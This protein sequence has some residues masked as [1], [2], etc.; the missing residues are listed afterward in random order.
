MKWVTRILVNSLV[1]LM[2]LFL[3]NVLGSYVGM[4]VGLNLA[5]AAIA[6]ILGVPGFALI[7]ILQYLGRV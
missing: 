1:G 6:G 2:A 4:S 7:L 3:F 5:N